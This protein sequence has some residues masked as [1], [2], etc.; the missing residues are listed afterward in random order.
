[1]A[2]S[3]S[4]PDT[5]INHTAEVASAVSVA[6]AQARMTNVHRLDP[7]QKV[8]YRR[9]NGISILVTNRDPQLI[10]RAQNA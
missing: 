7:R 10:R 5:P 4:V 1:M 9:L 8:G 6:L 2:G 3:S